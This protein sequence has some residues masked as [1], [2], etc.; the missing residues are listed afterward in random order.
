MTAPPDLPPEGGPLEGGGDAVARA[1]G[2]AEGDAGDAGDGPAGLD[3]ASLGEWLHDARVRAGLTLAEAE[4]GTRISGVYLEAIEADRFE[5]L[6][7]PIYARGFVRSYARYLGLDEQRARDMLPADMPRPVG[8]EPLP[9]L[10]RSRVGA[11]PSFNGPRVLALAVVLL[12]V[13]AMALGVSRLVGGGEERESAPVAAPATPVVSVPPFEPGQTPDFTGVQ[14]EVAEQVLNDLELPFV[15]IEVATR[16]APAGQV[17]GQSPQPGE[18][19]KP[20]DDVMLVVSA[21][22]P[23]AP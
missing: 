22:P 15:V 5:V 23:A 13:I 2:A 9:G 1:G 16:E 19:V 11:L 8:L 14:R 18:P 17:F 3:G 10:R 20:G 12:L 4:H 21:G 6:P 7:A